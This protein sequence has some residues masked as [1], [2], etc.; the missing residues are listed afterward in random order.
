MSDLTDDDLDD[1]IEQITAD[2]SD[3]QAAFVAFQAAIAGVRLP[4]DA[5]V[6]GEKVDLLAVHFDG[7]PRRGLVAVCKRKGRKH[8]VSLADVSVV[9]PG[10]VADHLAAYRRWLGI[11]PRAEGKLA[12]RAT[13]SKAPAPGA[14]VEAVLL[15]VGQRAARIRLLD[16]D[17]EEVTLRA[18]EAW[19]Y[20]PGQ[21]IT[22]EPRKRW[23]HN[24]YPCMSGE[25]T[26]ARIDIAAL[27]LEP[28]TVEPFGVW[29]P[30]SAEPYEGKLADLWRKIVRK[31]PRSTYEVELLTPG[32]DPDR[33]EMP[34]VEVA[35]E[36]YMA[37]DRSECWSI[38]A[39]VLLKDLRCIEAHMLLGAWHQDTL[40]HQALR[41][42]EVAVAIIDFSLGDNFDGVIPWECDGN[43]S[44][45]ATLGNYGRCLWQLGRVDDARAV[46]ERVLWLNPNDPTRLRASLLDLRTGTVWDDRSCTDFD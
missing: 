20:V 24:N 14:P 7:N 3:E 27:G 2:A 30:N 44:V 43:R 12:G 36:L 34:A 37:G 16:G 17:R 8:V 10:I 25:I 11:D 41:H 45:I 9:D 21:I 33:D 6:L 22:I 1:L 29:S 5:T 32:F 39:D 28:L 15:K 35:N 40:P 46:F 19:S 4:V 23:T 13:G 31:G 18:K 42:F 38:L 26:G